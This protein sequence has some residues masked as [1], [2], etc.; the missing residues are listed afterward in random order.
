MSEEGTNGSQWSTKLVPASQEATDLWE[1]MTEG[2]P[3]RNE[4]EEETPLDG[5]MPPLR[6]E[7]VA[8]TTPT[9]LSASSEVGSTPAILG[10]STSKA[11]GKTMR[12]KLNHLYRNYGNYSRPSGFGRAGEKIAFSPNEACSCEFMHTN[13]ADCGGILDLV[14]YDPPLVAYPVVV[15]EACMLCDDGC[16][17][18][19]EERLADATNV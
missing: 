14:L 15:L 13:C 11:K 5:W 4:N 7:S 3:P 12:E 9:L 17:C 2:N 6:Q 16:F 18:E 1:W 10:T 8:T 19:Y